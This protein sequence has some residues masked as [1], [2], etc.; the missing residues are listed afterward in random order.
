MKKNKVLAIIALLAVI[1][2]SALQ[3]ASCVTD[4]GN[5]P[6]PETGDTG[7]TD[8]TGSPGWT[9]A[10][11]WLQTKKT[12]YTVTDGTATETIKAESPTE[13][14]I[15]NWASSTKYEQ[16]STTT[17]ASGYQTTYKKRDGLNE[18]NILEGLMTISGTEY[19][20]FMHTKNVYDSAT[21]LLVVKSTSIDKDGVEGEPEE[22]SY[23]LLSDS[24]GI[25]TYKITESVFT[26]EKSIQNGSVI[27]EK[28]STS[29]GTYYYTTIYNVPT[30]EVIRTKIPNFKLEDME[31]NG[32]V[33]ADKKQ[34]VEVVSDT[35]TTL[36][37]R[38]KTFTK[39]IYGTPP[40]EFA[41]S[42]QSEIEYKKFSAPYTK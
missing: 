15:Y 36:V 8:D 35:D 24:G 10:D 28:V 23:E 30:N 40:F 34:E 11:V 19:P 25:K 32:S 37:I 2:F 6:P 33:Y 41:L 14:L 26:R 17:T 29:D 31:G 18:E 1:G 39:P 27:K 22:T 7:D 4:E 5:T 13:W 38:V 12:D 20:L 9:A 16:K 3:F 21:G 42:D